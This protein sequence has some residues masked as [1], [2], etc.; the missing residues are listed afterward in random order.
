MLPRAF[1][2]SVYFVLVHLVRVLTR[3]WGM[4]QLQLEQRRV[5][6]QNFFGPLGRPNTQMSPTRMPSATAC[7]RVP[8]PKVSWMSCTSVLTVRSE[9]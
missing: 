7:A 6:V 2:S 5:G 8:T 3:T 9:S 1:R 4:S